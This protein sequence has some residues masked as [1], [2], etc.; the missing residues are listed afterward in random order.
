M[1]KGE[2]QRA[3]KVVKILD[4]FHFFAYSR[5]IPLCKE[6]HMAQKKRERTKELDRRRKRRAERLRQRVREAKAN[7]NAKSR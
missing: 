2:K 7:V 1:V 4:A 5:H 6:F 3:A